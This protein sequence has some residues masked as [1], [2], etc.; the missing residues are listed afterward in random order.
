[1]ATSAATYFPA[2]KIEN[3]GTFVDGGVQCNNPTEIA[4]DKTWIQTRKYIYFITWYWNLFRIF[5]K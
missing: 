1:M 5:F 3:Y 4:L 2:H